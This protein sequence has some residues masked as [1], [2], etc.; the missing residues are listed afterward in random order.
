MILLE[1]DHVLAIDELS[2]LT[3]ISQ[4]LNSSL[5]ISNG[6]KTGPYISTWRIY[7]IANKFIKEPLI[8][9]S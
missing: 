7:I 8:N 3:E 9:S 1:V 6:L 4:D 2:K 5:S